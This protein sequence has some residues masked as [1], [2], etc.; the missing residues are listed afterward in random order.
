MLIFSQFIIHFNEKHVI[1][2]ILEILKIQS[3]QFS[4]VKDNMVRNLIELT[5][6]YA[7]RGTLLNKKVFS[8]LG[9]VMID[10]LSNKDESFIE[11]KIN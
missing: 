9:K 6:H 10:H 1:S 2:K 5:K 7:I 8:K 4:E 3:Q 11:K